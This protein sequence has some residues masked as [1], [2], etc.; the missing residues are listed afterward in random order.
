MDLPCILSTIAKIQKGQRLGSV[1]E[2]L[3]GLVSR[4]YMA[5]RVSLQDLQ[6]GGGDPNIS[7]VQI[8]C[9]R[10]PSVTFSNSS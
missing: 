3:A 8:S 6:G 10:S 5:T 1:Y 4:V 7:G 9:D 2:W